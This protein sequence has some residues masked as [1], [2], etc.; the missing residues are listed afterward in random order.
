MKTAITELIE[1]LQSLLN[2]LGVM[3]HNSISKIEKAT[4]NEI[5]KEIVKKY[6]KGINGTIKRFCEVIAFIFFVLLLSF[7]TLSFYWLIHWVICGRNVY[8]DAF[9]LVDFYK[10]E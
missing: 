2:G 1:E 6:S 3:Q 4:D 9:K 10:N 8:L 7:V 5:E